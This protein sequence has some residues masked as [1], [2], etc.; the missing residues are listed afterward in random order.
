[1]RHP[2]SLR[3][4]TRELSLWIVHLEASEQKF[5]Q[6]LA[7]LSPEETERAE[8]F[9]FDRHRRAFVLGR[10][11]LRA[12]LGSYLDIAPDAVRFEFGPQGKPRL[13]GTS[14]PLQFNASNSGHLAAYAFTA[15]CEI[16][17]DLE[18]HRAMLDLENIARRFFSPEETAELLELPASEKTAAFF[19]CWT[20]KE[21][22][23]KALGG[24]LSIPLDSFQVTLRPD[25]AARMV[26]LGGS[27][28]AA[29]GWM[30]HDFTPA[31]DYAGA[32]AYPGLLR[33]VETRTAASIDELSDELQVEPA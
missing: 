26:S 28:Q 18:Q 4:N 11:A 24:G 33:S 30:L 7:W 27:S 14:S 23:I 1:M 9:R 13:A 19:R 21:A 32:I 20:R 10:A 16:G 5:E 31:P 3:S 6:S 22:F 8:R 17:V 15:G 25:D 29:R 2:G 12:L